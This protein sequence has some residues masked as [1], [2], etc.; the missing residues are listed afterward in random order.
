MIAPEQPIVPPR[1]VGAKRTKQGGH[2]QKYFL[3][4][5]GRKLIMDLYDGTKERTD[6]IQKYMPLV[7]RKIISKWA[8]ELGKGHSRSRSN[9]TYKE[10]Q[11]LR[12]YIGKVSMRQLKI[13]LGK[14][15]GAIERRAYDLGLYK[16]YN[17]DNYTMQDIVLSLGAE[18]RTIHRWIEKGWLK[19][20]KGIF[21]FNDDIWVFLPKDIREFILAHPGALNQHKFDWLWVA[22]ILSGELGL[23]GLGPHRKGEST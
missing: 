4:E 21:G 18:D 5:R 3:D 19:G 1:K 17:T 14:G 6:M 11:V 2:P 20:R 8:S 9:W 13:M 22:D 23:G 7:P 16:E 15:R 10:E 12:Q